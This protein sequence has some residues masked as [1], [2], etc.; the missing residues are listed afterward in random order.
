MEQFHFKGFSPNPQ[1]RMKANRLYSRLLEEAPS[2]ATISGV[3]EWDGELYQCSIEIGSRIYPIAVSTNH[4]NAGIALD[5]A[6][7]TLSRK[8]AKFGVSF[9]PSEQGRASARVAAVTS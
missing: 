5:K 4:R 3:L 2:G 8:L 1:T 7:L 6:E 9:T